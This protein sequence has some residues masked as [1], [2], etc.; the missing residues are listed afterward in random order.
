M[1]K[2]ANCRL[3]S[4]KESADKNREKPTLFCFLL[5]PPNNQNK[6]PTRPM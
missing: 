3:K 2:A 4:Q 1:A 5:N 6:G